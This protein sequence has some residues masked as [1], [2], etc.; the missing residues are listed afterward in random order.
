MNQ[1]K[2]L[3]LISL[4]N[5]IAVVT[6]GASG[7]GRGVAMCLA[8]MGAKVALL[9]IQEAGALETIKLIS[10]QEGEA[11]FFYC[12]VTSD[13]SCKQAVDK[14]RESF[15]KVDTLV[16]CAGVVVRKD[17]VNLAEKEWDLVMDVTLKG[18]YLV[19]HHVL[20]LMMEQG[21]SVINIGSGWSLKGGPDAAAYCA[22][23]G[24]VVNLT[25]SMAI[26]YGKHNIRV[27]SVCPGDID[28]PLLRSE[29]RQ[30]G[31]DIDEFMA[32]AADRPIQR[33]GMPE[34]VASAVLY[35]AGDMSKWVTGATLVVDG[36]GLA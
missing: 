25:R 20:P 34:D 29:A 2:A 5:K 31:E 6:G 8:E 30:L 7:I 18:T 14:I 35:F 15:G 24:G 32:E 17:V 28:T 4:E 1:N 12:N 10:Q 11:K 16:N 36:G 23:K 22:A 19:S 9:D 33:V 27:N 3:E 21:G 26:D 13:A